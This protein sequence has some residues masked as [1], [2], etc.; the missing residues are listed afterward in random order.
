MI[1]ESFDSGDTRIDLTSGSITGSLVGS[2]ND[3]TIESHVTSGK[4]SLPGN[5]GSGA[6][7]LYA[8][9]TSGNINLSFEE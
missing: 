2:I 7:K 8:E 4:N 5:Y 3:Y 1:L 9:L 6:R